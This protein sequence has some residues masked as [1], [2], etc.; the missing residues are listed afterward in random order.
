MR[1][2]TPREISMIDPTLR[3]VIRSLV[4]GEI[5][6]P[7]FLTG[8]PGRGKTAAVLC[9]ADYVENA[10]YFRFPSLLKSFLWASQPGGVMIHRQR[11][12]EHSREPLTWYTE[13]RD[14]RGLF[15][16]LT[17]VPLLVIDDVGTRSSYTDAQFDNFYE[18]VDDRKRKPTVIA[19][20][21]SLDDLG[22]VFD[23][24]IKSRISRGTLF[25][26]QG[27]DRRLSK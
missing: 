27:N 6:W 25:T 5:P 24:R 2:D 9:L 16:Y 10:A 19:S 21:L 18:V 15:A 11:W 1:D 4:K 23:D 14:E 7:L 13:T 22:I 20:N 17:T 3:S 26:L 12:Q 8:L